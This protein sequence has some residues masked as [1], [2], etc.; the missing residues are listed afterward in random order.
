LINRIWRG[1]TLRDRP[2]KSKSDPNPIGTGYQVLGTGL[3]LQ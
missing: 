1:L 2:E 3:K